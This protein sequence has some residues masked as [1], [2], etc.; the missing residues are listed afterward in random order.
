MRKTVSRIQSHFL[1]CQTQKPVT[2]HQALLLC[3]NCEPDATENLHPNALANVIVSRARENIKYD[4]D[5][6]MNI[7]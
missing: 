2:S 1:K 4:H 3:L 6:N 5:V 7:F